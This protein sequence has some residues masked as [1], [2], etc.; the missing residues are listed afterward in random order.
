VLI[1]MLLAVAVVGGLSAVA[2]GGDNERRLGD[3]ALRPGDSG[4]DVA[5]L[6]DALGAAGLAV[7]QDGVFSADTE[8]AVQR[9]QAVVRLYPSGAVGRKTLAALRAA[10]TPATSNV[11]GF[12]RETADQQRH[13]LGDRVPVAPGMSGHD[14]RVLQASL[15]RAAFAGVRVN[16]E[17][18]RRT[19]SAV[20]EFERVATRRVDGTL[21]AGDIFV[22]R[23][24]IGH[25]VVAMASRESVAQPKLAPGEHAGLSPDGQAIAPAGAPP[26]VVRFIAAANAIATKPYRYG[27]G[28]GRWEDSGYDCSGS[29]SYALHGAGLVIAPMASGGYMSWGE[30]G[31]GRWVTLYS[32]PGHMYAVVAGLRFDTSGRT[33]TG[34]RWQTTTRAAGNYTV[35]HPP[36]L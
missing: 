5:E 22:L 25:D 26:A 24:A 13:R 36:G 15:R 10:N 19:R 3:R 30:A 32:N 28:H 6:Q 16:G 2:W 4:S 9:F 21:D 12:A 7:A 14:V 29:V 8:L 11:G 34:S 20:R 31:P 27:G 35:R 18:D 17:F 23:T 33:A 1:V